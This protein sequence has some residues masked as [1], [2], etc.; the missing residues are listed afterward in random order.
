MR[1]TQKVYDTRQRELKRELKAAT[2]KHGEAALVAAENG[3]DSK[4]VDELLEVVRRLERERDNL[5]AAWKAGTEAR[6]R[7]A[8]EQAASAE[9]QRKL[10][11]YTKIADSLDAYSSKIVAIEKA[12]ATVGQLCREFTEARSAFRLAASA[13]PPAERDNL[14]EMILPELM[15]VARLFTRVVDPNWNH[16]EIDPKSSILD[17]GLQGIEKARSKALEFT[18]AV[19]DEPADARPAFTVRPKEKPAK[20]YGP[21]ENWGVAPGYQVPPPR[22]GPSSQ[23]VTSH[24]ISKRLGH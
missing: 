22:T 5:E 11:T 6:Q 9:Q 17:W 4:A 3:T 7:A 10:A 21:G 16:H 20:M 2:K 19:D 8:E 1:L 13:L 23:D 18:G 12:A 24:V 15:H 14:R